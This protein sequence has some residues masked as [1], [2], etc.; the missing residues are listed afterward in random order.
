[1]SKKNIHTCILCGKEYKYCPSC[2]YN[3][4]AWKSI[5]DKEDCMTIFE[6]TRDYEHNLLTK[7]QAKEKIKDCDV[8]DKDNFFGNKKT[9]VE[10]IL[11]EPVPEKQ[12]QKNSQKYLKRQN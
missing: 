2:D 4:P 9:L 6:V 7:E 8:S 12:E 11:A 3:L 10:E 5:Y 1:M